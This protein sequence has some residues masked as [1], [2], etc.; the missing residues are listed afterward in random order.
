MFEV[1]GE[2]DSA[3]E[4]NMTAEGLKAEGDTESLYALAK[5]NG[6]EKEDVD[7]FLDGCMDELVNPLMAALGKIEIEKQELKP[8]HIMA[9]WVSYIETKCAKD[10]RIARA[11]RMKGKSIKGC[12][13]EIFK[14]ANK[15]RKPVNADI[16]KAAGFSGGRVELGM[17]G[18]ADVLGIIDKYYLGK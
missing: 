15:I 17:P 10:E 12:I 5:E 11:V 16:L 3:E 6:I 13:A 8:E 2:F 1:F 18:M 4:I 7:D 14:S 9:D